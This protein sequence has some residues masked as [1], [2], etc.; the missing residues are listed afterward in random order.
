[1]L[2]RKREIIEDYDVC[3]KKFLFLN[4]LS[5]DKVKIFFII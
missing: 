1:M 2:K 5:I 4:Y 3:F